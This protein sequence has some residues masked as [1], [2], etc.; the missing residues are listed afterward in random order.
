MI[1]R[2]QFLAAVISCIGT[3]VGH[4]GRTIGKA[5]DCVGVPWAS[6]VACGMHLEPTTRYRRLP[7]GEE[8]RAGLS[9]YCDEV[10]HVADAHILQVY[11]G[12]EPRHVVV[13][14]GLRD[15]GAVRVVHAWRKNGVVQEAVL[16]DRVWRWWRIRGVA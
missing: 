3:P 12:A 16:V 6:C 5:L 7:T 11:A 14:V 4:Y 15:D 1:A 8:L 13:P 2:E 9:Q 10:G